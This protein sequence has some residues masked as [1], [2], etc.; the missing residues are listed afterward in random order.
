MESSDGVFA[1][2][3][4]VRGVLLLAVH[5]SSLVRHL[6]PSAEQGCDRGEAAFRMI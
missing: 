2:L 6:L 1:C 3:F 4:N 5:M